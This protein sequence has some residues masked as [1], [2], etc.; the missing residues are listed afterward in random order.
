MHPRAAG[1]TQGHVTFSIFDA[2]FQKSIWETLPPPIL[3]DRPMTTND[4]EYPWFDKF[5]NLAPK[6]WMESVRCAQEMGGIKSAGTIEDLAAALSLD[7]KKFT[8]A[9]KAWNAKAA[10]GKIDEFGRLP[11]NMKPILK[12][13]FYG[14]KSG[15]LLGSTYCGARVNYRFEVLD[16]NHDSI[17]GLYAAGLSA[18]GMNGEGMF[19]ATALSSV[20]LAFSTGW[21]AGDNATSSASTYTPKEMVIESEVFEQRM[22]NTVN[23]H[24][25]GLG[26][27]VINFAFS[28]QKKKK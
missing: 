1:A 26:A 8:A 6:D 5:Q 14:I 2:D 27:F 21:I 3:D 12:P 16:K 28:R 4:P 15:P 19:Q 20:G 13:P 22:L 18:G 24:L 25:P 23:K 10:A 7:P 17:P 9:V 11:Q